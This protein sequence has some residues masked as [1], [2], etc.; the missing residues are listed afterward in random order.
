MV[1]HI[2]GRTSDL[3]VKTRGLE[4]YVFML[5]TKRRVRGLEKIA[6]KRILRFN[7]SAEYYLG[8]LIKEDKLGGICGASGAE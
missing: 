7:I 4:K 1:S 6:E 3:Y 2:K 5:K 8:D